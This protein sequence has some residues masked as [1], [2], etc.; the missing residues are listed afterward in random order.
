METQVVGAKRWPE[1]RTGCEERACARTRC[2]VGLEV[3]RPGTRGEP[4]L[5]EHVRNQVY[6]RVLRL[7]CAAPV[8]WVKQG[9]SSVLCG[10]SYRAEPDPA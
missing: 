5:I 2:S 7:S 6:G 10:V 1:L 3:E 9:E 4:G 8:G